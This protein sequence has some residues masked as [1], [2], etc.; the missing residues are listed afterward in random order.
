MTMPNSFLIEP[1]FK[2]S[3]DAYVDTGRPTGGFLEAVLSN[4]LFEAIG[5]ADGRA[6]DNLPHIVCYIYNETPS[7]CN[8]SN[9]KVNEW[10]R[11]R[12]KASQ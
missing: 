7:G 6:L 8:G 2:E 9:S 4:N 3:I 10:I 1:R 5:R 12:N 11:L